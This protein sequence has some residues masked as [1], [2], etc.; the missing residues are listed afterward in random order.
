[1]YLG[2]SYGNNVLFYTM[3]RP[4]VEEL[5]VKMHNS[6]VTLYIYVVVRII[7]R[8]FYSAKSQHNFT[9]Y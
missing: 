4:T 2:K 8:H 6:R 9:I 5:R 3:I 7:I 1:M